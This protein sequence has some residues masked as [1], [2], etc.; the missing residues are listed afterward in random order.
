MS[1]KL[2]SGE[3]LQAEKK[4]PLPRCAIGLLRH[5]GEGEAYGHFFQHWNLSFFCWKSRKHLGEL[6]TLAV[7]SSSFWL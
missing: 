7:T 5:T 3:E 4:S 1:G 6:D 2:S